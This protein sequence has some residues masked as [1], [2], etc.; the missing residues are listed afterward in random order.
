M[1]NRYLHDNLDLNRCDVGQVWKI[2]WIHQLAYLR[3]RHAVLSVPS[4]AEVLIAGLAHKGLLMFDI[5]RVRNRLQRGVA[6]FRARLFRRKP[7]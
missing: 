3:T 2:K 4:V 7:G 6:R 1:K 5:I